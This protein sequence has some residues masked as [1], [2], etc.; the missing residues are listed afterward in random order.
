[1]YSYK[2]IK[3]EKVNTKNNATD[4]RKREKKEQNR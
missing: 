2:L 3:G 4:L 1:M